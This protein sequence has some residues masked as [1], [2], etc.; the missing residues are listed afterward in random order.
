ML[1]FMLIRNSGNTSFLNVKEAVAE[2]P[3]SIHR[4]GREARYAAAQRGSSWKKHML[5]PDLSQAV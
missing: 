2:F 3:G 1:L 4:N 5:T